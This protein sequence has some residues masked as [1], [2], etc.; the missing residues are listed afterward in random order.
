MK[1]NVMLTP[2]VFIERIAVGGET[3]T[4]AQFV[5]RYAESRRWRGGGRCFMAPNES[6]HGRAA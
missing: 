1:T 4:Y 6:T 3:L 5:G 2:L